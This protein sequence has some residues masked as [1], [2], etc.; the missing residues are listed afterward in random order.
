[1]SGM[2]A[3][4]ASRF[5]VEFIPMIMAGVSART[6]WSTAG[7]SEVCG[8]KPG[9]GLCFGEQMLWG[10]TMWA[11]G[12]TLVGAVVPVMSL[13][14][15][16]LLKPKLWDSAVVTHSYWPFHSVP[17][18]LSGLSPLPLLTPLSSPLLCYLISGP[19]PNQPVCSIS[20]P[21]QH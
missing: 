3:Q 17:H 4:N 11:P 1:M 20:F 10:E 2:E 13:R 16:V 5:E 7:F 6:L 8:G 18:F 21:S 19:C 14:D 9:L 15:K 12:N